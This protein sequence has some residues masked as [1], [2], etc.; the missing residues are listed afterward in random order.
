MLRL[1]VVLPLLAACR[2]D[3]SVTPPHDDAGPADAQIDPDASATLPALFHF[4]VV[5]DTRPANED[6]V[7]G[8][9]T[10]IITQIWK[11]VQAVSPRPDFAVSTGDYVFANSAMAGSASTVDPQLDHYLTARSA[12]TNAVFPAMGNHECTGATA[13]NCGM[14]AVDGI[15][16]N[17][18]EYERRMLAPLG[19]T[20]PWF[21][22]PFAANDA[23]WTAKLVFVAANA[24]NPTQAAWLDQT[25]AQ[26][27]TYTF[28]IRHE[29]A[30]VTD[31]V[32]VT[33]SETTIAKYPLTLKIVGH[34]HTYTRDTADHEVIC[35]NGGAPPTSG[36]SYGYA[37]VE[38]LASGDIQVSEHDYESNAVTDQWRIHADGTDAP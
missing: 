22:I 4:A 11:D 30:Q 16:F 27:T 9:P 17:M 23:S 5:G 36:H 10:T 21:S 12:Y 25:L 3:S 20:T 18:A 13:S 2:G 19:I 6:D 1:V 26:P 28:V 32:G 35:G 14:G 8:Y 7:A 33:P 38:R 24:W 37:I 15:T 31:P 29:S 34:T